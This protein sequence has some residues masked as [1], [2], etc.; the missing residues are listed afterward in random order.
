MLTRLNVGLFVA[1]VV[2]TVAVLGAVVATPPAA[3][4]S[5][6]YWDQDGGTYVGPR[7]NCGTSERIE[8]Q[9]GDTSYPVDA[10]EAADTLLVPVR[11]FG[12][13]GAKIDYGSDSHVAATLGGRSLDLTPGMHTVSIVDNGTKSD[14]AW[15]LCP[16][17]INDVTYVPL[18]PAADAFGLMV[19]WAPGAVKLEAGSATGVQAD[20]AAECPVS[21]L[22]A[23]LGIT[24]VHGQVD[25]PF[26]LGIGVLTVDPSGSA[27]AIGLHPKDVI[28]S[29][30]D[31]RVTCPRDLEEALTAGD[32]S[33]CNYTLTV[34]RDGAK[35]ILEASPK[36]G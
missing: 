20:A 21:K 16:R 31:K 32:A 28:L 22:Q 8:L 17:V 1:L 33:P 11:V 4:D 29:Y 18:R 15:D 25:G 9:F 34:I 14:V 13:I 6:A 35:V 12:L 5:R 23:K 7:Y 24:A 27:A 30:N 3:A 19:N 36:A 10:L 26:G 2:A